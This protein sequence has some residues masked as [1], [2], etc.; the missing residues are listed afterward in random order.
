MIRSIIRNVASILRYLVAFI[1]L[2]FVLNFKTFSSSSKNSTEA[3][4]HALKEQKE[5][6]IDRF[7]L[8]CEPQFNKFF[9]SF[10]KERMEVISDLDLYAN[11]VLK[12]KKRRIQTIIKCLEKIYTF[13]KDVKGMNLHDFKKKM[14]SILN[15]KVFE[16]KFS[17]FQLPN[18][19]RNHSVED[20]KKSLYMMLDVVNSRNYQRIKDNKEAQK[21]SELRF[22]QQ[23]YVKDIV[24]LET[25]ISGE[26]IINSEHLKN[27]PELQKM[28]Q[29]ATA[30]ML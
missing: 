4:V 10:K 14:E 22:L 21:N 24:E 25:G 29:D 17:E 5:D 12:G 19:S 11:V 9:K 15:S 20:I 27:E 7:F 23:R 28:I 3:I 13:S 26:E 2:Q 1:L 30:K 6:T 8:V 16:D 18:E